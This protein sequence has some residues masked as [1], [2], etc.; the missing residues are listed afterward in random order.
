MK[1]LTQYGPEITR[2]ILSLENDEILPSDVRRHL[3]AVIA[4][5]N[6]QN[7]IRI[8]YKFLT[9]KDVITRKKASKNIKKLIS[10]NPSLRIDKRRITKLILT[11]SKYYKNTIY[12][13]ES[14]NILINAAVIEQSQDKSA[15]DRLVAR[16]GVVML[17]IEQL[18]Q[19]LETIF[20]LLSLRY[21]Q[22]DITAAYYG[23][24]S[25]D[26]EAKINAI[27]FLDNL[28]HIRLKSNILPLLEFNFIDPSN[29]SSLIQKTD[30]LNEYNIIKM[31]TQ[32]RGERMKL[33]MLHLIEASN[34][35]KYKSILNHISVH[36]DRALKEQAQRVLLNLK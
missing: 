32:N 5:F 29:E 33:A 2:T 20:A 12:A 10:N 8:L 19:S 17:L 26:P 21:N 13:I 6:T 4:T 27:E 28:L 9:S 25:N 23:I 18:E 36:K 1:S 7:S 34:D 3:P 15:Y 14:F 31:L 22:E 30:I 11:E 35:S 24:K 16:E